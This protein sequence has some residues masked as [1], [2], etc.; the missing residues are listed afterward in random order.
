MQYLRYK[1]HRLWSLDTASPFADESGYGTNATLTGTSTKGLATSRYAAYSTVVN[2]TNYITFPQSVYISGKERQKFTLMASVFLPD[3]GG[4][5]DQQ[6]LSNLSRS[7]GLYINGNTVY[8][9]T[10]YASNGFAI[11]S[12]QI[13][14]NKKVDVAGVYTYTQNLLYVDGVLVDSIDITAAQQADVF[15]TTDGNLYAGRLNAE[16]LLIN[17]VAIYAKALTGDEIANIYDD[18]NYLS[19]TDPVYSNSGETVPVSADARTAFINQTF[20]SLDEWNGGVLTAAFVDAD[21]YLRPE[22]IGTQTMA[23]TWVD[24]L[25]IYAKGVASAINSI[26]LWWDGKNVTVDTS[27]DGGT[28]WVTATRGVNLSNVAPGFDPTDK[29]LMVRVTFTGNVTDAYIGNLRIV[30]FLSSTSQQPNGRVITYTAPVTTLPEQTPAQMREDWGAKA[31]GGTISIGTDTTSD[32][33]MTVQ[34][35]EL[36]VKQL[37]ATAPTFSTNLTTSTTRYTNGIVSS[38][39]R[40]GEWNVIHFTK[41][42]GITGAITISG[43]VQVGRVALYSTQLSATQI[44]NEV[45]NYTGR[46]VAT[47]AAG[48]PVSIVEPVTSA[49]IYAHDW[50]NV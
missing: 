41:S 14:L 4:T 36:W 9:A 38:T 13:P 28:T 33:A 29:V 47:R 50:A 26:W 5:G 18:N 16:N 48:G 20:D 44:A 49:N 3:T 10:A 17:T 43:Q 22:M 42:S 39:I 32:T 35:V 23:G 7:D 24:T 15:A 2:S 8:F 27:V 21:N 34:T 6:I 46:M 30:G 19:V 45:T 11:T 40:R 37:T 12:Y 31:Q 1:P 25:N